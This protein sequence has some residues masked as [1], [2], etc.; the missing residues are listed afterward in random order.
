[1]NKRIYLFLFLL[2]ILPSLFLACSAEDIK[3]DSTLES[4]QN[5]KS[6]GVFPLDIDMLNTDKYKEEIEEYLIKLNPKIDIL[7]SNY[8]FGDLDGDLFPELVVYVERDAKEL[9]DK[10]ALLVYHREFF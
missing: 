6:S 7:K 2:F 5:S 8:Q 9:N 1:M 10:G 3:M 4:M